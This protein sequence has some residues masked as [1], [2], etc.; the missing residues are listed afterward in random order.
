VFDRL[1]DERKVPGDARDLLW[2]ASGWKA[3]K[4]EIDETAMATLLDELKTRP[5][6]ARLFGGEAEPP[7]SGPTPPPTPAPGRG[8]GGRDLNNGKFRVTL[9]QVGDDAWV[10]AN[11]QRYQEALKTGNLEIID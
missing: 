11:Q 6:V 3:E 9:A 5:G 1:A 2:Q 10:Y 8:Q 4:D 7:P